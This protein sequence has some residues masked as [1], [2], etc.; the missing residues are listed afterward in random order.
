MP[1]SYQNRKLKKGETVGQHSNDVAVHVWQ[2]EKRVTFIL[3]ASV[4]YWLVC[5]L[6]A[7]RVT[8]SNMAETMDF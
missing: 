5:L 8:G 4:V 1:F 6:L 3:V 2:D 7:P